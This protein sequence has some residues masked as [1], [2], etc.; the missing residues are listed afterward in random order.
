MNHIYQDI[1]GWFSFPK[2][3]SEMVA[4]FP[5]GSRL[6]EIGTYHGCSFSYLVVEAINSGKKFDIVGIDALCWPDILPAFTENMKPLEGH[7]RTIFGGD[8]FDHAKDFEDG[9]IDFLF[10][11]GCHV[12]EFVKK[13]IENFLP[14]MKKGGIMAGHDFNEAH[15]GVMQA[16]LEAFIGDPNVKWD[17]NYCKPNREDGKPGNGLTYKKDEDTWIVQL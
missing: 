12:Y 4:R 9:S 7:F 2:L 10:I 14:K 5:S 17:G 8:S 16:V 11:D 13:D 6:V 1:K 3:Y 15:P